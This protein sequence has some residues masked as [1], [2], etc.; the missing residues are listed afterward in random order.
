MKNFE[1]KQIK[2]YLNKK[3]KTGEFSV[4]ERKSI[5]DSFE[6]YLGDEFLGLIY[7]EDEDGELA[8]QFHMTILN[9]DLLDS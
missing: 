9:E 7:K 2:D 8:Y 4:R 3:F 5:D 6:I 1:Q